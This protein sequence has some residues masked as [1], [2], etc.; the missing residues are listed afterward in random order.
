MR[1]CRPRLSAE[2]RLVHPEVVV[3]LGAT[4]GKALL[5]PSFRVTKDRGALLALPSEEHGTTDGRTESA[6][7]LL[8]ATIHPSAILRSEERETAYA[9]FLSDLRVAA[10]ALD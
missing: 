7:G 1:A 2:L 6:P 8:V 4:A 3:A 10:G 5:G 9:G